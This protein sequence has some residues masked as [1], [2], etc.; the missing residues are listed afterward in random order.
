MSQSTPPGWYP[1][2]QGGQRWWDGNQWTEHTLPQDSSDRPASS[3]QPTQP[4]PSNVTQVRPGGP[5]G[6]EQPGADRPGGA[7]SGQPPAAMP[8]QV[9][10][11]GGPGQP[12]AQPGAQQPGYPG[13]QQPGYPGA[14]QQGGYGQQPGYPGAQQQGGYPGQPGQPPWQGQHHPGG[15]TGGGLNAKLL[16]L[17]GGGA[18]V[19]IILI[20]VLFVVLGGSGG[21]KGVVEDFLDADSCSD[22]EELVSKDF[23]ENFGE[24]TDEQLE[25]LD[26]GEEGDFDTEVKDEKID[27]DKATVE[28]EV[29][30]SFGGE[31]FEETSEYTL[32][33]ED[34]DWKIDSIG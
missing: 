34:G 13:A 10:G 22:A 8:T 12:G 2:G 16:G 17:I 14:Q 30:G 19:V 23:K 33:K 27:G 5:T 32:I 6:Q 9:A 11:S 21:P 1:D 29:S 28:V 20:I 4:G 26:G 25:G 15:S 7:E 18:A 24:C 31:D 3:E